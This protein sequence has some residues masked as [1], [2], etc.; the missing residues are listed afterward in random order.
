MYEN[1]VKVHDLTFIFGCN[2]KHCCVCPVTHP[3]LVLLKISNVESLDRWR[4]SEHGKP[5]WWL[6]SFGVDCLDAAFVW[7]CVDGLPRR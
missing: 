4:M 5:S 7:H 2:L 3:D 1:T 6:S